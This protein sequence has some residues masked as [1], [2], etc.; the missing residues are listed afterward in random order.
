MFRYEIEYTSNAR[1]SVLKKKLAGMCEG[2]WSVQRAGTSF[3]L[4]AG[5][6]YRLC[7]ERESDLLTLLR[8]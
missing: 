7:F 3:L 8:P 4:G 6:R 5:R 2:A 1:L